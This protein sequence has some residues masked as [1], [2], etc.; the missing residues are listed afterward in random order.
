M[1]PAAAAIRVLLADDHR[2]LLGS[3]R[4]LLERHGCIVVGEATTGEEAVALAMRVRPQVVVMDL[5][6]P[7]TGGLAAAHRMAKLVPAAKVLILSAHDED[8][9]VIEALSEAGVAGYLVKSD[10]PDELI[11]A[12]HIVS[13]G[14]RY[15]SPSVAPILLGRLKDPQA[16]KRGARSAIT[17]R[18]REVLRLIGQG[19]TSKDIAQTLGINPKTAQVHRENLKDKLGLRTTA[20]IVRY[21]IK[22]KIVKLG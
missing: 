17:R 4:A 9:D 19:A 16:G 15:L 3:L 5:E 2:V 6:M 8:N 22:H 11:N 13:G 14:R 18:E 1:N 21:A 12:V 10:A 7:G 20:D